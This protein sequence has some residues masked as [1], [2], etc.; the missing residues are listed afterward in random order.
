M[1]LTSEE[2]LK[3]IDTLTQDQRL[4]TKEFF[5][6]WN[7]SSSLSNTN[8]FISFHIVQNT[9]GGRL[10]S[11][12][13]SF[14]HKRPMTHKKS[15]LHWTRKNSRHTREREKKIPENPSPCTMKKKVINHL[16]FR[17]AKETLICQK[18]PPPLKLVQSYYFPLRSLPSKESHLR[19]RARFPNTT[20]REQ[21]RIFR[22]QDRIKRFDRKG[23]TPQS[24]PSH[25]IFHLPLHPKSLD[26]LQKMLH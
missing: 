17:E 19:R 1:K 12:F 11:I 26:L 3:S 10:P 13:M 23:A 8:K 7:E 18:E 6:L 16:C 22:L 5:N 4:H 20:T 9:Q 24:S 25:Y 14:T 21:R 15:F 2:G